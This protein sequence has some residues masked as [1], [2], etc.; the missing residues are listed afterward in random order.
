MKHFWE[1][2]G[3]EWG[4]YGYFRVTYGSLVSEPRKVLWRS[5]RYQKSPK[6]RSSEVHESFKNVSLCPMKIEGVS[7]DFRGAPFLERKGY[8]RDSI[9]RNRRM[10]FQGHS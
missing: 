6:R 9:P 2:H 7:K 4:F 10:G 5:M 3:A 8:Q 1:F